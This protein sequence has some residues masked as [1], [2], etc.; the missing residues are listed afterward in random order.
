MADNSRDKKKSLI[1][2]TLLFLLAGGGG[3]M[4]MVIQGSNDLTGAGK[5]NFTYGSAAREGVSSFFKYIGLDTADEHIVSKSGEIR[6]ESK[7]V[8]IGEPVVKSSDISD[9]M[10]PSASKSQASAAPS[11]VP[12]M[13]SAGLSGAGGIGGGGSKSAGGLS[14]YG[15]GSSSGNTSVSK[16]GAAA[17]GGVAGKGTLASLTRT[18]ALLREGMSS[19]SAMGAKGKWDSSFGV[20]RSGSGGN[21]T[22]GKPGLVNLDG[23]KKG[24]IGNLKIAD[25]KSLKVTDPSQFERDKDAE[26]KDSVLNAAKEE[27]KK[28][29]EEAAKKAAAQAAMQAAINGASGTSGNT[30]PK[31][32]PAG[33]GTGGAG[34]TIPQSV[35]QTVNNMFCTNDCTNAGGVVSDTNAVVAP[36]P[37]GNYTVTYLGTKMIDGVSTP[38]AEV[39]EVSPSGAVIGQKR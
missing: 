1:V 7:G 6:A 17:A 8:V 37:N 23:I 19:G 11:V 34:A 13:A 9:W 25:A 33:G 5:K 35:T 32:A 15:E 29:A 28:A 31:A 2:F 14:R 26:S 39:W 22:Y 18:N 36:N 21:L 3:F 10:A 4:Y 12:R 27:A 38:N 20:G 24:T 30:T 16:N